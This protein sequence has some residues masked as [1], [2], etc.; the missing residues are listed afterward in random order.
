[1]EEFTHKTNICDRQYL[2]RRQAAAAKT[3]AKTAAKQHNSSGGGGGDVAA[4]AAADND[5]GNGNG[6]DDSTPA[7]AGSAP[8]PTDA[9]KQ[10]MMAAGAVETVMAWAAAAG[11][12]GAGGQHIGAAA[13]TVMAGAVPHVDPQLPVAER[14]LVSTL[15]L[16]N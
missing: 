13:E 16:I 14:R 15:V 12:K 3:A 9:P 5:N 8:A 2:R 1:V 10:E 4:A 11:L 7:A 6:N